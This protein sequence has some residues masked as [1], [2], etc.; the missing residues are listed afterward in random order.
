[1][2]HHHDTHAQA[3]S[4]AEQQGDSCCSTKSAHTDGPHVHSEQHRVTEIR[5]CCGTKRNTADSAAPDTRDPGVDLKNSIDPVC[6]MRVG[7]DSPHSV[8]HEGQLYVFCS[9]GCRAKFA[10]D[11][12]KYATHRDDHVGHVAAPSR[13]PDTDV[14]PGTIYT[15][16]MH[17]QVRQVGP[18]NCPICGMALEP[19]VPAEEEDDGEIRKVRAKFWIALAFALP[20]VGIAMLPHLLDLHLSETV[21]RVLRGAE[22][23]LSAPVVLWAALDY[24][25][26]GWMG[27]VNRSPN[28][29]TLIGLGVLVAFSYS[30]VASAA[31]QAFPS[32]MRDAHGMV[33]VYFEVASAIVALVLLGEWLELRARGRTSAAIRQLLG[34]AAKTAR[35]VKADGT[36]EDVPLAEVHAGDQLRVR[37]GEKIPVDGR[38]LDGHS[39][40]DESM[41]TGEPMP[42]DKSAGDRIV[43]ATINQ[44]GTLVIVAERVG[45]DSL[46]SQIV[47]LA[48]QAQRSRAP[49]QRLADKVA[50]WFVPSVIFIAVL[51]FVAWWFVGPEPRLAYAIVNAVAVLIIACPCALGLATP[52]SIMVASGRGA[53]LGVLFRDAQAIENLRDVDTLVLD[54]TGTITVGRPAF[55]RVI[56][57]TGFSD[58][59]VLSW[60]A[61]LD[62]TSE[63]PLARAV[64]AG[65]ESRG[66]RPAAVT[67]FI[68]VTGQ[69]VRGESEGQALALGNT[70]LMT[71]ANVSTGSIAHEVEQ[72]RRQGRTVF[73]LSADG[74]LAGAIAV[75][76][77]IKE[78]TPTALRAL[79]EDG[80]KLIMLTGDNAA[81]ARAVAAA[82]PIDEVI[83]EVQP[84]DK[85]DVIARLQSQG[86]RVAMAGD[87]INDA[88]ALARA[89]VGIAMG[90]GTDIAMESAQ[91]TLVKGDLRGIVRARQL[92][93][94]T[95][96]NIRQNLF[97]A[98]GYNA[99]G[100]PIA[101]GLLYPL[102]GSLLSPLIAAF[103]MSLSSVSV[104]TNALRLRQQA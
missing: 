94:A 82:L 47:S 55:D 19:E 49:L 88:P 41:L 30:I 2:K 1:M 62:R 29:Y 9:A 33:G 32:D 63:H 61:G 93:R 46:L 69:G 27:V 89:D 70:A 84:Q 75:G 18:G 83:A 78:T 85:A 23:L 77:P 96:R 99:L 104:I 8:T 31:P 16:P 58:E 101:A 34:L 24:Y 53:Q 36:E 80:L 17:P 56:T 97:F 22:L 37:P 86:A 38:V 50:A 35:R 68:S 7:N 10:A 60:A 64:V 67:N 57:V 43:G 81:T 48:A 13:Q 91:V 5:T 14:S 45:A 6:G 100:I 66:V 52:I 4:D 26:R 87:G 98:F 15:C 39:S 11:P 90:T 28:M 95:V 103:A 44:T 76:D 42:V 71:S 72:L 79:K 54:K 51:T 92:S 102:T 20:V 59:Q 12:P 3:N 65:A 73:F 74:K 25:R 21:A 40:V